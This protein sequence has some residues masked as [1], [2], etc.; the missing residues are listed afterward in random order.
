MHGFIGG[1]MSN[2]VDLHIGL[3]IGTSTSK[4]VIKPKYSTDNN[5]YLVDFGKYG[6]KNSTY[7]LPTAVVKK[8]NEVCLLKSNE[9]DGLVYR[10]LK[11]KYLKNPDNKN[12]QLLLCL[13]IALILKYAKKWFNDNYGMTDAYKNKIIKWT[14]HAGIPTKDHYDTKISAYKKLIQHSLAIINK[15]ETM[16]AA[17]YIHPEIYAAIQSYINRDNVKPEGFYGAID[18]GAGTVDIAIF[19]IVAKEDTG[20][21]TYNTLGTDVKYI[22]ANEYKGALLKVLRAYGYKERAKALDR[23]FLL[24]NYIEEDKRMYCKGLPEERDII[25]K[26]QKNEEKFKKTFWAQLGKVGI[27]RHNPNSPIFK[28]G[29]GKL[30][31]FISGGGSNISIYKTVINE[32]SKSMVHSYVNFK[33]IEIMDVDDTEVVSTCMTNINKLYTA[34]AIGLSSFDVS[35]ESEDKQYISPDR[36]KKV[37]IYAPVQNIKEAPTKDEC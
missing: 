29:E 5:Y 10:N 26:M 11:I 18:V 25:E 34:V 16:D 7:L 8:K 2:I 14:I 22:G 27:K 24:R 3:D 37:E 4:V 28:K 15:C 32:M 12:A 1:K 33:G 20:N 35:D 19:T 13:Y 30:P 6:I 31:F 9:K 17:I 23:K 36:L 21:L